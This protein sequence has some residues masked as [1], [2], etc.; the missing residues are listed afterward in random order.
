MI[1]NWK[2]SFP[3][4]RRRVQLEDFTKEFESVRDDVKTTNVRNK[5]LISVAVI[6]WT[7]F[8]GLIGVYFQHSFTEYDK[9]ITKIEVIDK[10]LADNKDVPEKIEEIKKSLTE[11]EKRLNEL[12]NRVKQ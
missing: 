10:K 3:P 4:R 5:T 9:N 11:L 8:G 12:E 1:P 2:C 7:V 6:I